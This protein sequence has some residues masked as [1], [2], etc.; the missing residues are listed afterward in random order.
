MLLLRQTYC[1]SNLVPCIQDALVLDKEA[2]KSIFRMEHS[3]YK[4][5][6]ILRD[7]EEEAKKV[8]T[9]IQALMQCSRK[10]SLRISTGKFLLVAQDLP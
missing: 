7:I 9:S 10:N 3:V 5:G 1:K 6:S 4:A 8:F 2:L